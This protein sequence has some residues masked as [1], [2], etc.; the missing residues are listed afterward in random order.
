MWKY[1]FESAA[2]THAG[3]MRRWNESAEPWK[4]L[5]G[6]LFLLGGIVLVS[7]LLTFRS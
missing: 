2:G 1:L 6:E 7:S 4:R 3:S 5:L